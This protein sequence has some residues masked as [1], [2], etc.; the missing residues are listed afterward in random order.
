M[1]SDVT[2]DNWTYGIKNQ[3]NNSKCDNTFNS[4]VEAQMKLSAPID[5]Y[6]VTTHTAETAYEKVLSY[7]GCSKQ[8]DS[9]DITMVNDVRDGKTTY[10]GSG[11][12]P[13]F[14]NNQNDCGGWPALNST[15]APTDTDGDGMPD[16]WETA[17]GLNPNDATDGAKI[18]ADGYTNLE[19]YL[20]G[21]V[22]DIT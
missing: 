20:N 8:R 16:E 22:A 11:N 9:Y 19:H 1:H 15:A 10:T 7:V 12:N 13:G 6:A 21:L 3:I 18:C 2:N 14:I 17:N 5:F 4:E